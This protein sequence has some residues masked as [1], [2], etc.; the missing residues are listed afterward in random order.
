M[1]CFVSLL[2]IIIIITIIVIIYS[3]I[4]LT[5]GKFEARRPMMHR[6]AFFQIAWYTARLF[7]NRTLTYTPYFFIYLEF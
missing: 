1:R 5:I 6:A 7:T 4:I 2:I 3:I